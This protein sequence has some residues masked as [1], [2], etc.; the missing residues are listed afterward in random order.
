[1]QKYVEAETSN[2]PLVKSRVGRFSL[3]VWV[4][5]RVLPV[6][7]GFDAERERIQ[8]RICLQYSRWDW[9]KREWQRQSV[10]F[11][12]EELRDLNNAIEQLENE[13]LQAGLQ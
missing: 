10:W 4:K 2:R 11:N 12:P 9:T 5:K 1:M 8:E 3:S 13:R 7:H 6:R